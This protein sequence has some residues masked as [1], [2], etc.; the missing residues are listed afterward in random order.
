MSLKNQQGTL[1][2]KRDGQAGRIEETSESKM[3][4]GLASFDVKCKHLYHFR[5]GLLIKEICFKSR[6]SPHIDVLSEM[7]EKLT[8]QRESGNRKFCPKGAPEEESEESASHHMVVDELIDVPEESTR[9][10]CGASAT[11]RRE[12][13][14]RRQKTNCRLVWRVST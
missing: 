12:E 3:S 5:A 1:R 10:F 13:S 8:D 7:R 6:G 11:A 2:S 14:R 4:F 9:N